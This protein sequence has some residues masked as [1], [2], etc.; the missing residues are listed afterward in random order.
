MTSTRRFTAWPPR[1]TTRATNCIRKALTPR[2]VSGWKATRSSG[3]PGS[4]STPKRMRAGRRTR[5]RSRM[6]MVRPRRRHRA[7]P[8]MPRLPQPQAPQRARWRPTRPCRR[9]VRSSPAAADRW[10]TA[11]SSDR[12]SELRCDSLCPRFP[13]KATYEAVCQQCKAHS[14]PCAEKWS[15]ARA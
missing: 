5:G 2:R 11:S 1:T 6:P 15:R 4:S 8:P 3:R 10:R 7:I 12:Q 14:R 9:C 13:H